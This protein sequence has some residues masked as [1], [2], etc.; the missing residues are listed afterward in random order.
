MSPAPILRPTLNSRV[1]PLPYWRRA[2]PDDIQGLGKE[3]PMISLP[4]RSRASRAGGACKRRVAGS[5]RMGGNQPVKTH[6]QDRPACR[7]VAITAV[8]VELYPGREHHVIAPALHFGRSRCGP[9]IHPC[10]AARRHPHRLRYRHVA[11]ACHASA[12]AA[13]GIRQPERAPLRRHSSRLSLRL[14][15]MSTRLCSRSLSLA[16]AQAGGGFFRWVPPCRAASAVTDGG[17]R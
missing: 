10:V 4:G 13:H 5:Q 17:L 8:V 15:G 11:S 7:R 16:R 14:T 1:G 9:R 2:T 3:A 6:D 12:D